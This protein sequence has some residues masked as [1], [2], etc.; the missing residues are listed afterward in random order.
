MDVK[1]KFSYG[2]ELGYKDFNVIIQWQ[3]VLGLTKGM[4][5]ALC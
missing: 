5:L 1:A 3:P 4:A 2:A